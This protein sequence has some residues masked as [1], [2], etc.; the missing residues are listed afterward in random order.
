VR[1]DVTLF[2]KVQLQF[3]LRGVTD[4]QAAD[5]LEAFKAR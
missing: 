3:A 2:N 4:Q 5:L 1:Q